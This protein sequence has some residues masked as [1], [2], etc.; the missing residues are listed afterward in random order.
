MSTNYS[1]IVSL[2]ILKTG[3]TLLFW[4]SLL[5]FCAVL[6]QEAK[7]CLIGKYHFFSINPALA[8]ANPNDRTTLR[9]GG[10]LIH[11]NPASLSLSFAY[12]DANAF[13]K[14]SW[15]YAAI[16]IPYAFQ[17]LIFLYLLWC[18]KKVIDTIGTDSVFQHANV[19]RI[20]WI[21]VCLI[22]S[23]V[24][25]KLPWWFIKPF[26]VGLLRQNNI[27]YSSPASYNVV[28]NWLTGLLI[29]ALAEVFR[30]GVELKQENELTI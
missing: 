22:L 20:R 13:R 5:L 8:V 12:D 16:Y 14:D 4:A 17:G 25:S 18:L 2:R 7:D 28:G 6:I 1:Y 10:R 11:I 23:E 21:G 30:Q 29:I 19:R 27:G 15:V 24:I 26:I 3:V 9:E